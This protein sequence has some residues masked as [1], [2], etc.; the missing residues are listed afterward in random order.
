M[1]SL[2]RVPNAEIFDGNP[3]DV[4]D[5]ASRTARAC[6]GRGDGEAASLHRHSL[7]ARAGDGR[8]EAAASARQIAASHLKNLRTAALPCALA[9]F[10]AACAPTLGDFERPAPSVLSDDVMPRVGKL[11]AEKHRKEPVSDFRLTDHEREL[12][13]RA[14]SLLM[15]QLEKQFFMGWLAE[16][17]RTRIMTVEKTV[18]KRGDYV[19]EL[20]ST[21]FRSSGARFARLEMDI[22][23]DRVRYPLFVDAANTVASF[24]RVRERSLSEVP[25]ASAEEIQ[26]AYGRIEENRL[27]VYAVQTSM[28]ERA[29]TY[30]YA[31]QRLMIETP[32]ATAIG[33]E[34]AL[35][36]LER[37]IGVL[38]FG[39]PQKLAVHGK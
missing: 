13:D 38:P 32:D 19:R 30:R 29:D 11:V 15:P 33:A 36:A 22:Q 8:R 10:L 18:P 17:R 24:D 25:D 20:L 6:A 4:S 31:F 3:S 1:A 21:N 14:W 37:D 12:R 28:R 16:F 26:N 27:V 7:R 34:R 2:G 23:N 9:A 35:M 39:M 5:P